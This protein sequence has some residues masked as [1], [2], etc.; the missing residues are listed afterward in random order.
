MV[1]IA[2]SPGGR[3][4]ALGTVKWGGIMF[5]EVPVRS[6]A[7]ARKLGIMEWNG[8]DGL[9]FIAKAGRSHR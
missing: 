3:G 6:F 5:L 9:R 2:G 7:A 4:I 8:R 1:C